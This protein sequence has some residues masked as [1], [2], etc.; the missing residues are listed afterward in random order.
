MNDTNLN[1]CYVI[2]RIKNGVVHV[3]LVPTTPKNSQH[4]KTIQNKI[5]GGGA[6][7]RD[8]SPVATGSRETKEETGLRKR[9]R[10]NPIFLCRTTN[11]LGHVKEAYLAPRL[12]FRGSLRLKPTEDQDSFLEPPIEVPLEE[13][14]KIVFQ[15]T[16]NKFHLNALLSAHDM[17]VKM[18]VIQSP[19]F[20]TS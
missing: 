8:K 18:G 12:G 7:K 5:P 2:W 3:I 11:K 1:V 14:L 17:L 4:G 9:L 6:E 13:A 10:I 16:R 19:A 20:A 15:T